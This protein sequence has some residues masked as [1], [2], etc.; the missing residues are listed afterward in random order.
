MSHHNEPSSPLKTEQLKSGE[1]VLDPHAI[2]IFGGNANPRLAR[3]VAE[4]I[5]QPLGDMIITRFSDGELRCAINE[6]I[7]GADV[8][9]IQPTCAPVNDTLME[10]LILCDA[11]KRASARRIVPI[12]P[13]FGYG[14]Q[15]KK[16][17]PRE[18][19]TAK[20]VA[21]MITHAGADRIFAIDLHAGQIQGFFDIPVDHLPGQPLIADYLMSKGVQGKGVT[22][23][24]PDV[25]G[26]ERATILA[27]KLGAELAIVAKRRPEPGKVKIVEVIGD[28]E[29]QTCVLIDDMIDSGGTFVAAANELAWRGAKEIYGCATHPVLSGDAIRRIQD[30]AIMELIVTDTI[31]IAPERKIPKLTQL[32][33][34]LVCAEAILRIHQNDS[35]SGMFDEMW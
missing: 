29:G 19:I 34:G 30:S 6:S 28:I 35:V 17:R 10:L 8:F 11:F 27:E 1:L 5:G 33:V 32:S 24:S 21:N 13:Y 3:D 4:I 2:K 26:V 16:I 23:V 22:V 31:P 12:I 18:P 7:R 9:I 20:L 15:D 25:G 14:R